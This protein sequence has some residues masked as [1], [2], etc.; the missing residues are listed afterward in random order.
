MTSEQQP[1]VV[2]PPTPET[3]PVAPEPPAEPGR[4]FTEADV[5]R[6]VKD[7]LE[8]SKR[9]ADAAATK[10]ADDARQKALAEQGDFQRL[11]DERAQRIAQLEPQAAQLD[12]YKA[13]LQ[14]VLA[15]RRKDLPAH[16]TT[17][18]DRLTEVE[19]LEYLTAHAGQLRP[20]VPPPNFNGQTARAAS[21]DPEERRRDLEQRFPALKRR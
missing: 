15:E 20:T 4:T 1:E 9:S 11:A 10:A 18:L 13:A 16:L 8:R 12:A 7:R 2:P 6:I 19:Q 21:P 5:E 17:L 3:A 14:H